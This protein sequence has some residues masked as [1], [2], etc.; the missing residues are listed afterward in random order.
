MIPKFRVWVKIG[1][2]MVF[3]DDILA[4][5]YE[6]KEIV[7][8]QVYFENG[9]PDDRDIYCYDFDEIELMQSTGLKDKNGK[10]VFI[11][12][13]VKCTRG[14]LHEV[15]LEKEYGGTFIGGMPSIYLKG[16]LSGYAWT[17]YEEIIGN[18]YE[19]P[20]LLEVNE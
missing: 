9:L 20:E 6:N 3:S 2:R 19:N 5:D 14:C 16:F 11:G 4:I 13:I 17:E 8:Q 15:Y 12:D 7:T 10:E 18:I 1:K